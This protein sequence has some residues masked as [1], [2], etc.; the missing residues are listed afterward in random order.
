MHQMRTHLPNLALPV[1]VGACLIG[2]DD[3]IVRLEVRAEMTTERIEL[4][5]QVQER[6]SGHDCFRGVS[7]FEMEARTPDG[8]IVPLYEREYGELSGTYVADTLGIVDS[9][10]YF[11]DDTQYTLESPAPY[12]ATLVMT[13]E[14]QIQ[15]SPP[16]ADGDAMR[17]NFTYGGAEGTGGGSIGPYADHVSLKN[18]RPDAYRVLVQRER[19]TTLTEADDPLRPPGL[20]SFDWVFDVVIE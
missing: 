5:A 10:T 4:R 11:L 19:H 2:C 3:A 18:L 14:P 8:R 13:P 15:W 17:V 1:L 12:T 16:T 20:V 6:C 7:G 9:Y